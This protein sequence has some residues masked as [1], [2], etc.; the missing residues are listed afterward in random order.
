[1]HQIY[2]L[3]KLVFETRFKSEFNQMLKALN[4]SSWTNAII[5]CFKQ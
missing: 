3:N 2:I 4:N 5:T 1:M